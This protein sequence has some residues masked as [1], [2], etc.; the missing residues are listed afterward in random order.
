MYAGMHA[1]LQETRIQP[2]PGAGVSQQLLSAAH[3]HAHRL[4]ATL[5]SRNGERVAC[6]KGPCP[7]A[8][9]AALTL[10]LPL[11]AA[12]AW[13]SSSGHKALRH[14]S[15]DSRSKGCGSGTSSALSIAEVAMD[16]ALKG[17]L[18]GRF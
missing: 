3:M 15:S 12:L 11:S 7:T 5:R 9:T 2:C 1:W 18:T 8:K 13:R 14:T 17:W 6:L 10:Q 16:L 4:L